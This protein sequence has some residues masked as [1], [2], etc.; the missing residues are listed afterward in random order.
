MALAQEVGRVPPRV[1]AHIGDHARA[2]RRPAL[3]RHIRHRAAIYFDIAQRVRG[4]AS[5]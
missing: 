5:I 4:G 2:N 1:P 3:D